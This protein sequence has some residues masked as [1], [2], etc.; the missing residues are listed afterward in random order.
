MKGKEHT[1][2]LV[3]RVNSSDQSPM[4]NHLVVEEVLPFVRKRPLAKPGLDKGGHLLN[5]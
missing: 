4:S 3:Q 5:Q 1:V 2:L